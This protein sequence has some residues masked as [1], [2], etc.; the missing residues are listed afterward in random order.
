MLRR[1]AAISKWAAVAMPAALSDGVIFISS[2]LIDSVV[3]VSLGSVYCV[4]GN[5]P[6]S[7]FLT[8]CQRS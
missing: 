2:G 8:S 5:L 4:A 7:I 6:Q 3:H 1:F